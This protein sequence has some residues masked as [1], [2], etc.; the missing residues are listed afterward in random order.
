MSHITAMTKVVY[1]AKLYDKDE[2]FVDEGGDRDYLEFAI[3][4]AENLV[5]DAV[6]KTGEHHFAKIEINVLPVYM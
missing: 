2:N 5:S 1:V 3:E 4:D 6:R